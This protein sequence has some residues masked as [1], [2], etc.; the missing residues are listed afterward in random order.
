MSPSSA[1]NHPDPAH[2]PPPPAAATPGAAGA[3][4]RTRVRC[5]LAD[6]TARARSD[7]PRARGAGQDRGADAREARQVTSPRTPTPSRCAGPLAA[8]ILRVRARG[9][10]P[11]PSSQCSRAR[12]AYILHNPPT[13]TPHL[14]PSPAP[15]PRAPAIPFTDWQ[16][17]LR[18]LPGRPGSRPGSPGPAASA[19]P[20]D[21][22]RLTSDGAFVPFGVRVGVKSPRRGCILRYCYRQR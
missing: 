17:A 9:L 16:A 20:N 5:A 18:E 11:S 12:P 15:L 10:P 19:A 21:W 1:P 4:R 2:D 14:H 13:F 7:G 22:Q 8:N 3:E 6:R